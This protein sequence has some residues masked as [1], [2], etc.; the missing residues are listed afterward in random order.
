MWDK[1][2]AWC[3]HSATIAWG[4]LQVLSGTI[5]AGLHYLGDVVTDPDVKS[6]IQTMKLP[7]YVILGILA[8]GAITIAVRLRTLQQATTPENQVIP[9]VVVDK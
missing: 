7:A 5:L 4:Y 6:L 1:I 2:K 9:Q 8:F 3:Y